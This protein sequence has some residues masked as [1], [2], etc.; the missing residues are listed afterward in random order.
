MDTQSDYELILDLLGSELQE[1]FGGELPV[2]AGR[3]M[4]EVLR[5]RQAESGLDGACFVP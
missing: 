1:Y 5:E 4:D 2:S 3:T